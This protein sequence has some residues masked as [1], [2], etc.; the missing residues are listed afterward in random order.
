MAEASL[1]Y[2]WWH[3][4]WT[5]FRAWPPTDERG[6]WRELAALYAR[7]AETGVAVKVSAPLP[8]RWQGRPQ[9]PGTVQ[10]PDAAKELVATDLRKLAASDRVAGDTPLRTL[11]V[12]AESVQVLLSCPPPALHQR[13]GRLKSRTATLLSFAPGLNCGGYGTWGKGFW[14][15]CLEDEVAVSSVSAFVAECGRASG[16]TEEPLTE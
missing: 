2:P 4:V 1:G 5:T 7:L 16:S 11:A 12:R 10:L 14:W 15:A 9:P 13:V 8:Q 6:D 3:V